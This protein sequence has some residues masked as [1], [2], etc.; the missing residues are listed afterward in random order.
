MKYCPPVAQT[1]YASSTLH[2][3]GGVRP[4]ILCVMRLIIIFHRKCKCCSCLASLCAVVFVSCSFCCSGHITVAGF[5]QFGF[6]SKKKAELTQAT[7]SFTSY[8]L[9]EGEIS[10]SGS[11][12]NECMHRK[13]S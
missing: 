4:E 11:P 9:V 1:V 6:K 7:D 8:D 3:V 13:L 2:K 5:V 12:G 10:Q